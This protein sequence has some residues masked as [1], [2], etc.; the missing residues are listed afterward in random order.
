MALCEI[1]VI[2]AEDYVYVIKLTFC[3]SPPFNF[4]SIIS[5]GPRRVTTHDHDR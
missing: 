1:Q 4:V 3:D 5:R 2:C